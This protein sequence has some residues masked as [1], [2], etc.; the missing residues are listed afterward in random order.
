MAMERVCVQTDAWVR[1]LQG[2]VGEVP[3]IVRVPQMVPESE[4]RSERSVRENPKKHSG[5]SQCLQRFT[6]A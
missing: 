3:V 1:D 4:I 2:E 6:V 5:P